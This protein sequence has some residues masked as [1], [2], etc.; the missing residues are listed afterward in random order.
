MVQIWTHI[1]SLYVSFSYFVKSQDHS[2]ILAF[3]ISCTMTASSSPV[4]P[5]FLL[6]QKHWIHVIDDNC[7]NRLFFF[8]LRI[9]GV[10]CR[11]CRILT[12][13]TWDL[14]VTSRYWVASPSVLGEV[15][16]LQAI[17][18][19]RRHMASGRVW[20]NLPLKKLQV[21]SLPVPCQRGCL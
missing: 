3:K 1:R 5:H 9:S 19:R 18:K 13:N 16:L 11:A 12:S 21:V 20:A 14:Y 4:S 6:A 17:R 10:F 2:S 7:L 8:R 15:A